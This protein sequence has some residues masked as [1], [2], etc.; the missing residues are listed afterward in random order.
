MHPQG[1]ICPRLGTPALDEFP[2][3]WLTKNQ[4]SSGDLVTCPHK[5]ARYTNRNVTFICTLEHLPHATQYER[6]GANLI[7]QLYHVIGMARK[8]SYYLWA[9]KQSTVKITW[10]IVHLLPL[11]KMK[12]ANWEFTNKCFV[13][14]TPKLHGNNSAMHRNQVNLRTVAETCQ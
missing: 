8:R 10:N 13:I 11:H 1:Y 7:K 2:S 14:S 9:I 12:K 5:L 4:K 3:S 6:H